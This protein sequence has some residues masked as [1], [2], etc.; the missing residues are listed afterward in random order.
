LGVSILGVSI[1]AVKPNPETSR[2][3][4][5]QT[6]ENLLR[7]ADEAI[8][9]RRNAAVEQERS[10]KENELNTE[11]AIE[12]KK[13]QI[14]E[15]QME[16]ER[17]VQQK[18][19]EMT[20]ADMQ[21]QIALEDERKKLVALATENS[22]QEAEAKAYTVSKLLEA[23]SSVDAKTLQVLA[24]RNLSPEQLIS[25]AFVDLAGNAEKIGELN[26]S[27]DL[28]RDLLTKRKPN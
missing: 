26:I 10:I 13:R 9:E 16:A 15:T 4:E 18:Q 11:I 5:A 6:K 7:K 1:L 3:L 27:P 24:G 19:H 23:V 14:R 17:S 8:Y 12:E 25:Q 2:A 28:L 22:K 21:A 20:S